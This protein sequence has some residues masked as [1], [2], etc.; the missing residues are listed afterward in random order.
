MFKFRIIVTALTAA[1]CLAIGLS[2]IAGAAVP[3][4]VTLAKGGNVHGKVK[5]SNA[6]CV[7]NRKVTLFRVKGSVG[8]GDDIK[9]YSTTSESDGRYDMGNPGVT[10]GKRYY[11]KVKAFAG[12]SGAISNVVR[13]PF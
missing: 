5:S 2:S 1:L 4:K 13:E 6:S 9:V 3:T 10:P 7:A 11:V 12:C 8:G